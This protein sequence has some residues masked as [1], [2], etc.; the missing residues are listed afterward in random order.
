VSSGRSA[1]VVVMGSGPGG[2]TLAYAL[3][4]SGAKVLLLERGDFLPREPENW[5][6]R[7]V[8]LEKRYK[9]DETWLDG[10]GGTF[11]PGNHYFV[12]GN[13]KVYGACLARLRS[14][15]FDAY[16]LEDG[17][18]PAW[19][20]GYD[21]LEP[22]YAEAERIF[23]VHATAGDDPHD[24]P[25][26]APPPYPPVAHDPV[27]ADLAKRLEGQGLR[28]FALPM[29]L[30][31]RPG[32]ACVLSR[33]CDAF[34]CP[35]GAKSDAEVCCVRPAVES[36]GVELLTRARVRRLVTDPTGRRVVKAEIDHAGETVEVTGG[37]FALACG[38][39]NSAALLLRSASSAH[40]TGLANSS[41]QVG[42]NY[43]QHMN[44]ALMAVDPRRR[45]D[46]VF[47]KTL[48]VNDFYYRIPGAPGSMQLVGKVQPE[49]VV[50]Q[51]PRVPLRTARWLAERSVDWW[52]FTEDAPLPENRVTLA[53]GGRIRVSWRPTN[54]RAQRDLVRAC[55][56]A[57]RRAGYP[58]TLVERFGVATNSHQA[59][60]LRMGA[61]PATSVVDPLGKAHDL[62]NLY[63]VDGSFFP[64]LGGGPGGPTLTI[65][66][67]A[68]RVAARSDLTR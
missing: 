24:P 10:S 17:L 32:G 65:A 61:D 12:G 64:S 42:R 22:Y 56:R 27:I 41:D 44:A 49:M 46:T 25:R 8:F 14:T 9:A 37:A 19:P 63:V 60:T 66:A 58:L 28:P 2:A 48:G 57:M 47:Q 40:P 7:S 15:D 18:S 23:R 4:D 38:A 53:A 20:F 43:L 59:G 16:E 55:A 35:R 34:P 54:V 6:A 21:E 30:D 45:R 39:V 68:L 11:Q 5:S 3:R 62:D 51:R 67:H 26:S 13:T 1:D 29:G 36:G 50:A 52:L 33:S 31:V